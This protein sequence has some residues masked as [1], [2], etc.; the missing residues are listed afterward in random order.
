MAEMHEAVGG[1]SAF[2]CKMELDLVFR[3]HGREEK[4]E[5]KKSWN[6]MFSSER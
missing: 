4:K 3:Q 2:C 6:A 5:R 1:C